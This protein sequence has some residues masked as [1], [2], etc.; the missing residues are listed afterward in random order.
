MKTASRTF[1]RY[2]VR[3]ALACAFVHAS[4]PSTADAR[5]FD[6]K[7]ESVATYFGG[8]YGTS[9]VGDAAYG[10]AADAAV[11]TDKSVSTA[12]S[13]EFGLLLSGKKMNLKLGAEYL[14]PRAYTDV[15]GTDA[16]GTELFELSSKVTALIPM[17]TLEFLAYQGPT[18]RMLIG[19]GGGVAF[20]SVANQ[21]RPTAAAAGPFPGVAEHTEEASER[22]SSFV[23]YLGYETLF[24]DTVTVSIQAGY[25]HLP[26]RSLK[27][28]KANT[29][30]TG[31]QTEGSEILN[32][33]G[34]SRSLDLSGPFVGLS[35]RF[36]IGL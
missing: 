23:G 29:S 18:S 12:A 11:S 25:R 8:S 32:T 21:F 1:V 5:N 36:Y 7:S 34:S 17:A 9:R 35:L 20:V 4:S 31:N 14:L 16:A 19:V 33:N 24:T 13:G 27:A 6:F 22:V 28:T 30:F 3:M 15:K 10:F 2:T 26:V